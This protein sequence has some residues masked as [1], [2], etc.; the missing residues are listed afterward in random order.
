MKDNY[1]RNEQCRSRLCSLARG[2][3][4]AVLCDGCHR[5]V[6]VSCRFPPSSSSCH[7]SSCS[8]FLP[9][10]VSSSPPRLSSSSRPFSS[11][12]SRPSPAPA[13]HLIPPPLPHLAPLSRR[14]PSSS[15]PLVVVSPLLCIAFSL[16]LLVVVSPPHSAFL[17][18]PAPPAR[19]CPFVVIAVLVLPSWRRPRSSSSTLLRFVDPSPPPPQPSCSSS[20]T[21]LPPADYLPPPPRPSSFSSSTFLLSSPLGFDSPPGFNSPPGLDSQPRPGTRCRWVRLPAMCCRCR[22]V[23]LP[24][25]SH[26]RPGCR[27]RR[28]RSFASA[29]SAGRQVIV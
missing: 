13:S 11:S 21:L 3:R 26:H 9:F 28:R 17:H 1:K 7:P 5:C 12:S 14:F 20:S 25:R 19:F 8:S 4:R 24:C 18:P 16:P 10:S 22:W 23:R 15:F 29:A 2:T 6:G 27:C